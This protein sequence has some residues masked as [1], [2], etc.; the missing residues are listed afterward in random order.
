MSMFFQIYFILLFA[1]AGHRRASKERRRRRF[2]NPPQYLATDLLLK[3]LFSNSDDYSFMKL[4]V[5]VIGRSDSSKSEESISLRRER[6]GTRMRDV[7]RKE[8]K[9]RV[10]FTVSLTMTGTGHDS[11][12]LRSIPAFPSAALSSHQQP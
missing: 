7:K 5:P 10:W 2:N 12:S 6:E 9:R 11:V 1:A 3:K 4:K 8:E